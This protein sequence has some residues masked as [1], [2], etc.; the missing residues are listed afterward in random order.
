[1]SWDTAYTREEFPE[2]LRA[3]R[4]SGTI[5]RDWEEGFGLFL[6]AANQGAIANA[7]PVRIIAKKADK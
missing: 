4:D 7:G 6:L 2:G 5:L 3:I 1:V